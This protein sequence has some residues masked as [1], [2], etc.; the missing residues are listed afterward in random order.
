[1]LNYERSVQA[2]SMG[3]PVIS[4]NW[5]GLTEFLIEDVGYPIRVEAIVEAEGGDWFKHQR[6]AQ[7]SMTHLR[8]LMRQVVQNP[9]EGKHV[10][11]MRL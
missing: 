11:Q 8:Q 7:P 4:T 9:G 3:K 10:L 5:S 1:M 6:W 2:M